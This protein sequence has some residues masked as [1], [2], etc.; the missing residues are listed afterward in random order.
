[1]HNVTPKL[2]KIQL[3][4]LEWFK[5]LLIKLHGSLCA[6]ANYIGQCGL[7]VA[8]KEQDLIISIMAVGYDEQDLISG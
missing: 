4:L 1:M 6:L 2:D 3:K 5:Q 7:K 8:K